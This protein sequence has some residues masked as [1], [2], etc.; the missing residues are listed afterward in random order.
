HIQVSDQT[1]EK[2]KLLIRQGI[3]WEHLLTISSRHGTIPLL[4][5][6]LNTICPTSVPED[7]FQRLQNRFQTNARRNLFY[8][9]E[10]LKTLNLIADHNITAVP[11]KGPTL[12]A[13]VYGNLAF[14]S[15]GD[16]DIWVHKRDVS[17]VT[18]LLLAEGYQLLK[19]H[20]FE[21]TFRHPVTGVSIDLHY[22]LAHR[23]FRFSINFDE[24]RSRFK[25]GKL[26]G[27]TIDQLSPEDL[28]IVLCVLWGRDCYLWRMRL[29]QLCDINE[30]I[31][32]YPELNWQQVLDRARK[33]RG[34]RLLLMALASARNLLKT[35]LPAAVD[36]RLQ[37]DP[38]ANSLAAQIS[39]QFL[40]TIDARTDTDDPAY[41]S[42]LK[43]YKHHLLQMREHWLDG[44]PYFLHH[45]LV[46]QEEEI[47]LVPLP[48]FSFLRYPLRILRLI[49]KYGLKLLQG[50]L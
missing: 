23:L 19:D 11:F 25:P 30:L 3:D 28:L 12:A 33:L 1:A 43:I 10:L 14:R 41:Q 13:S 20:G 32:A 22:A 15:F 49:R 5:R 38:T 9:Y 40:D 17:A 50:G 46:P 47:A 21:D 6:S 18:N 2:I 35:P 7:I 8:T 31:R 39:S 27:K 4:Y 29:A 44:L 34:E 24:V 26:A 45:A 42:S 37:A 36:E 16:L 48:F